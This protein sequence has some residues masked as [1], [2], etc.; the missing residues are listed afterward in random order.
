MTRNADHII[1][2]GLICEQMYKKVGT[3]KIAFVT[4]MLK[5]R[6]L[7]EGGAYVLD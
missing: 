6:I 4:Y 3:R 2:N 1:E 7:F 5:G